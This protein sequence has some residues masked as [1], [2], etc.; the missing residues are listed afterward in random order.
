[1]GKFANSP[2]EVNRAALRAW[3]EDGCEGPEP[4]M[5]MQGAYLG[6]QA[7]RSQQ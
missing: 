3:Q 7:V 6:P 2:D 1:M 4:E 5:S